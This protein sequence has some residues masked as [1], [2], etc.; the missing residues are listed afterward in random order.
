[1][2]RGRSPTLSRP[3]AHSEP[4]ST[5]LA[6]PALSPA[7]SPLLASAPWPRHGVARV[8]RLLTSTVK[9]SPAKLS[10]VMRSFTTGTP[11]TR[12]AAQ[13]RGSS[14]VPWTRALPVIPCAASSGTSKKRSQ[15]GTSSERSSM[16]RSRV[17][18]MRSMVP[19]VVTRVS[20]TSL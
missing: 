4:P 17:P 20:P 12:S 5:P 18:W 7:L 19:R 11:E 9:S 2:T 13:A 14:R 1:M 6:W 10:Q 8:G 15:R 16:P 3:L